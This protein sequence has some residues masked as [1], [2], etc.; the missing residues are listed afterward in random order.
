[1]T[2]Q[3]G[4]DSMLTV[5]KTAWDLLGYP[6]TYTD[7]PAETPVADTVWARAIVRHA[8][9]GQGSLTGDSGTVKWDRRGVLWIQVFAPIGAGSV[10]GLQAAQQLINAYQAERGPVWYRNIRMNEMGA[11]GAWERFDVKADFEYDDVR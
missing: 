4:I 6:A 8:T 3:D 2:F 10:Q 7:I 1:M 11:D 5:F 9:G